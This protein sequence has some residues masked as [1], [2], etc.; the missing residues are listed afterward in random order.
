MKRHGRYIIMLGVIALTLV[1]L[2]LA[3]N[4]QSGS[5]QAPV[6]CPTEHVVDWLCKWYQHQI[7]GECR[8]LP[9]AGVPRNWVEVSPPGYCPPLQVEPTAT[10]T[11]TAVSTA[12]ATATNVPEEEATATAT[13][14]PGNQATVTPRATNPPLPTPPPHPPRQHP[15]GPGNLGFILF[16]GIAGLSILAVA[17]SFFR[18]SLLNKR[19]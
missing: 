12:T 17:V 4:L 13:T 15:G 18:R 11:A 19:S 3:L 2:F 8:W 1:A 6:L 16:G 10:A 7:T 14:D 9:S 5:A